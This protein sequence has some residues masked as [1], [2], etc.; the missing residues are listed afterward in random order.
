MSLAL[1]EQAGATHEDADGLINIP[2][3]VKDIQAVAFFKEIAPDSY[4][5][6]MRSKG[7]VDVNRVANTFGGGGHKNAAGCS[8]NGAYPDVRK[9]A[10]RGIVSFPDGVL[11]VNKPPG[12]TSHDVV[13]VTRRALRRSTLDDRRSTMDD[14]RST[15]KVGHTGTLDPLASGVL[16]L[17]IGKATRLAQFLSSAE[18]EYEADIEL[19]V[20]TTTLDR[21]GDVI[22]RGRVREVADVTGSMIEEAV[23]E[24]RGTYLQLPPAYSAKKIDGD[25]AYDLARKNTPARLEPVQV[26]ASVLEVMEWNANRLRLRLVC[27]AG[28]Y[29]R[30]LAEALGERLG[31]GA[32]LASLVRTR[33]G[34]FTLDHA[35]G[36]DVLDRTPRDA[37]AQV[38]P[39]AAL[40]PSLPAITLTVEGASLA[41][42][43]GFIGPSHLTG[44]EHLPETGK[45]R[46]LHPDGRLVA[47]AEP[48]ETHQRGSVRR[49][50]HPGVV[51]E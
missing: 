50:L 40:L 16:P 17:V 9:T 45:V 11:V 48:R 5:I 35:V 29:V 1:L 30:S 18:K 38:I 3:T 23:A 34:D 46:L 2:L 10:A 47:I 15:M 14:G 20:S 43:G 22:V 24:F 28:Y 51:L 19:G 4:R 41:A 12:P 42:R 36:L 8:L 31:T 39:I 7:D 32:H 13:A 6:S 21:G 27:S 37:A 25:R 26:T 49:F 33:S 44:D